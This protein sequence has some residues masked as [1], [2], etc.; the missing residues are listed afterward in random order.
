M[1]SLCRTWCSLSSHASAVSEKMCMHCIFITKTVNLLQCIYLKHQ[2]S[3]TSNYASRFIMLLYALVPKGRKKEVIYLGR[4]V[5]GKSICSLDLHKEAARLHYERH[6]LLVVLWYTGMQS[7]PSFSKATSLCSQFK[8]MM[9]KWNL[10]PD[11]MYIFE[12]FLFKVHLYLQFCFDFCS[13][14]CQILYFLY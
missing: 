7:F 11:W 12:I 3:I 9:E 8:E 14:Q 2:Y 13:C 10:N 5:Y 6:K 4:Y 1:L